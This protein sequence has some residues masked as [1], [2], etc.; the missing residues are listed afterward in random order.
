MKP[1]A[2][3]HRFC[4]NYSFL[5]ALVMKPRTFNVAISLSISVNDSNPRLY[6]TTIAKSAA[7]N[8]RI[9]IKSH[10]ASVISSQLEVMSFIE[11]ATLTPS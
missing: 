7:K 4:V 5:K 11:L 8:I 1:M 10:L 6:N 2:V 3:N 9:Y